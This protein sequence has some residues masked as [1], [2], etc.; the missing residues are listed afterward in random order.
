MSG[1]RGHRAWGSIKKQRTK[2]ASYQASFIGP[3]LRRHYGPHIFTD[4]MSAEAWLLNERIYRDRCSGTN[5]RW[6]SVEE[7]KNEKAARNLLFTDYG[8]KVLEQRKLKD[9][10]RSLYEDK[11]TQLIKPYFESVAVK[12]M[13]S[14]IVRAWF[15]GL[16]N[17]YPTRNAQAYTV[18]SMICATAV[19]DGLLLANPCTIRGATTVRPKPKGE[20]LSVNDVF[21]IANQLGS[22]DKYRQYKYLV[23]IAAFCGGTRIGE[24]TELR[25]KDVVMVRGIPSMLKVE[26][27]VTHRQG[28]KVTATK[29]ADQRRV[30][31]PKL[32]QADIQE[33]LASVP[34]D[35]EALLFRP[36]HGGTWKCDHLN[37]NSFNA[38]ILKRAAREAIG[39]ED[40]SA[41]SLRHAATTIANHAG[42]PVKESMSR[43][44][45]RSKQVHL[46]YID[47]ST[48]NG[49]A[50]AD[51]IS[52]YALTELNSDDQRA[53]A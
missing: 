8:T 37:P 53:S 30:D 43:T 28:C 27:G 18:L 2:T 50:M 24:A 23:L 34:S 41:H 13:S 40:I 42:L 52:D 10:S 51:R 25:R 1:K 7:R 48:H 12:D 45:H 49:K 20:P 39:R 4:K 17:E 38:N 6:R 15:A 29:T 46:D 44:G 32:I 19:E 36:I 3:D 33:L 21:S 31:I 22:Q 9:S 14:Q 16:G 47:H 5:E 35:P 26:R 11:W